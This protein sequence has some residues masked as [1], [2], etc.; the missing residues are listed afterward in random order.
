MDL[1]KL[2]LNNLI[3]NGGRT[4][5]L[6]FLVALLAFTV[7]GGTAIVS[8]LKNGLSSLEARLGADVIVVPAT[9]KST[10][11]LESIMLDG[12][13]GYFYMDESYVQK[14]AARE[15]VEKVSPQYYLATV[16]A[17]C[18]TMPVQIVG[19]DPETDFTIQ[20]WIDRSY[21]S[22]LGLH[23]VVAGCNITGAPGL[24][25]LF[26]GVECTIV[27]KLD[28]TGTALDNAV[29]CTSETIK[30]LIRGSQEQ[31]I[32]VLAD[33]DPDTIVSTVQVKVADGYNVTK[34][35]DD[36]NLH[37]RGATAVQARAMTSGVA[38]SMAGVSSTIG[39]LVAALW[40][41]AVAVLIIAFMMMGKQR[42]REFA[43]LRVLGASRKSLAGIVIAESLMVSAVGALIG[44][45][46]AGVILFAFKGA[47]EN[48]L[49]LP[50]LMPDVGQIAIMALVSLVM[51]LV[52]GPAASAASA[53]RLSKVDPGQ[54][55]R[56]E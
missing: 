36:I 17:G 5:L 8:S 45:A 25:I 31:G 2:P 33:N 21:Q 10:A 16:K 3:R 46:L 55:L 39:I 51:A 28:E 30:D 53:L 32:S 9:A 19:I 22:E 29:F 47:L 13:P 54:I 44:T 43:V 37:V 18:C 52:I 23:D 11:D 38:D 15:G 6:A 50:F 42:R 12:T 24:K 49:G 4:A 26:Y 34:V 56:E 40:V 35:V 14:V 27:S 48:A 1:K 20:P 41:L 7:F